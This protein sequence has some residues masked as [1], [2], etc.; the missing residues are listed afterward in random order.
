MIDFLKSSDSDNTSTVLKSSKIFNLERL[1]LPH[2]NAE[3]SEKKRCWLQ[4]FFLGRNNAATCALS[5]WENEKMLKY[6]MC[7]HTLRNSSI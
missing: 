5:H 3:L 1:A 6:A 4:C 2:N 7:T